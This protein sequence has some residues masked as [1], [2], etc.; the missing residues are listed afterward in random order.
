[1]LRDVIQRNVLDD[2]ASIVFLDYGLHLT[3]GKLRSAIQAQLDARAESHLVLIGYGLCGNGLVGL[4]SRRHTLIIPR[5]DDCISLFL[6]SRAAYLREFRAD[7]ATYYLTPGWLECGG[8]P[9]TDFG[10]CLE[11]YGPEK[12]ALIC[13]ALYAR[14]RRAC[15]VA[16]SA[17]D[18][19]RYRE[20]ALEVAAF[21]SERWGWQYEERAGSDELIRRLIQAGAEF[22]R[23]GA[24]AGICD[25]VTVAPGGEV[26][27]EPFMAGLFPPEDTGSCTTSTIR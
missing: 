2:G 9:R 14:Y 19:G 24:P 27:Q 1:V 8:E 6:G 15:F 13:D 18:L 17:E 26:L 22:D 7:P 11:K 16:A 20:R 25:F 10:R 3:P 4:Q 23:S 12:A 21:C 5:V